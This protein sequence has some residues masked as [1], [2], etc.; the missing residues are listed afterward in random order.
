MDII[1]VILKLI[2][3]LELSSTEGQR[4]LTKDCDD[5]RSNATIDSDD[6]TKAMY[7]RLHK[8]I[9]VRL[10]NP[11]LYY[12]VLNKMMNVLKGNESDKFL[13]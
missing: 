1:D 6:K 5:W 2:D 8:G 12:F 3:D 4:T 13:D 9:A 7:A 11:F 10:I